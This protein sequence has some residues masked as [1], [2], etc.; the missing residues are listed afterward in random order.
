MGK[1]IFRAPKKPESNVIMLESEQA[2]KTPITTEAMILASGYIAKDFEDGLRISGSPMPGRVTFN[3]YDDVFVEAGAGLKEGDKLLVVEPGEDVDDPDTGRE[4]GTI[5]I[6]N[7]VMDVKKKEGRF[8]LC[9][10]MYSFAP[11]SEDDTL[12]PYTRPV[13]VYDPIPKNPAL[14][15]KWGYIAAARDN[16]TMGTPISVIYLNMGSNDGV[17]PGDG[18]EIRRSGGTTG[19][20]IGRYTIFPRQRYARSKANPVFRDYTLPDILVGEA[21][22]ISV[23]PD[24]STA[25]VTYSNEGIMPG[26]RVYYKD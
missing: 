14:S 7:G 12:I 23:Q 19:A 2:E 5:V 17:K 24:S 22:V 16:V 13:L 15:G 18:F 25:Q 4:L 9:E 1:T 6:V 3:I 21:R 20:P 10:I 8:Y 11:I 26:Y